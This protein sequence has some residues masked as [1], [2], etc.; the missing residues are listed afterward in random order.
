MKIC[1]R[2]RETRGAA[3]KFTGRGG[4]GA[5]RVQRVPTRRSLAGRRPRIPLLGDGGGWQEVGLDRSSRGWNASK[6]RAEEGAESRAGRGSVAP[7]P[8]GH[9]HPADA[10]SPRLGA[11]SALL[12]PSAC[13]RAGGLRRPS[14]ATHGHIALSGLGAAAANTC[15]CGSRPK[16]RSQREEAG[17]RGI[18]GAWATAVVT[19]LAQAQPLQRGWDSHS[20]ILGDVVSRLKPIVYVLARQDPVS[21]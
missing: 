3:T 5:R 10:A 8:H 12:P 7:A 9:T 6:A 20:G 18:S 4:K 17:A 14:N 1:C 19:G 2:V 11:G 13:G 15:A 21:L 16:G